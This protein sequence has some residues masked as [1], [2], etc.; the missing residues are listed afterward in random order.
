MWPDPAAVHPALLQC[1]EQYSM[2]PFQAA[3][4]NVSSLTIHIGGHSL[5]AS[6][7]QGKAATFHLSD[8]L[9]AAGAC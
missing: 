5:G 8:R 4:C 9:A 3:E 2:V 1:V 6:G 7:L